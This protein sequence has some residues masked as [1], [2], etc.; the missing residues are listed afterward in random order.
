MTVMPHLDLGYRPRRQFE[1]FHRRKQRWACIV[2]HRRAGKT[3]ACIMDLIDA[4]LRCKKPDGRFGYVAPTFTQAKDV[5]WSYLKYYTHQ[6]PQTELRESDLSVILPN[7]ARVRLYG[8]DNFD[9]MRGLF[10]DGVVMDEYAD[11]YPQAWSQVIRPALAD[12]G[13]SAT[14]IGTPKGRNGFWEIH[15]RAKRDPEWFSL[16]LRAS[17]TGLLPE[18]ELESARS[19]LT[20]EQYAQEFECSFDAAILGAYFA[21]EIAE[22]ENAGRIGDVPVD[23]TLPVHTAWDLGIGDS[24][25]IW[26]FQVLG[27][28]VRVVDHYEAH[29]KGL[30]HYAG[31]L[32][33][34]GYDY[35]TDWLPHDGMAREMGTGRSRFETLR[36]LTGRH[37]RIGRNLSVEDG[38]NAARLTIASAWFDAERCRDGLEALRAYRA[39]FDERTKAFNNRPRHDWASHSADAFRYLAVAWREMQPEKPPERPQPDSWE[40]AFQ[41]AM[42]RDGYGAA[43]SWRV[44]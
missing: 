23:S 30:G 22:A 42:D 26:F 15:D 34:K 16:E 32:E 24:T 13:G 36:A 10:F 1:A 18:D 39:E 9:R 14:F 3:V 28:E 8:S 17:Q 4:A 40:R 6:I 20:P 11:Q 37:P 12:R 41:R 31:V 25:A 19:A 33:D 43:R 44:A 29:G 38:I 21:K 5:V 2:A 35:G 7:G 27:K